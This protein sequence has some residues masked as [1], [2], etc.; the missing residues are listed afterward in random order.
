MW[1]RRAAGA[2]LISLALGAC[3]DEHPLGIED[4]S[5]A[6]T[7][8]AANL[9][10][11]QG[12][13]KAVERASLLM[14]IPV[15]LTPDLHGWLSITELTVV[16]QL[17][18][19]QLFADGVISWIDEDGQY[20]AETFENHPITLTPT[21]QASTTNNSDWLSLQRGPAESG[22]CDILYLSLGPLFLDLLGLTVDLSNI[23]LDL[24]ALAGAGNLLGN[25]LCAVTSL[26]DLGPLAALLNLLAQIN[27][28]LD[29]INDLLSGLDAI[30]NI[31]SGDA[32]A[33]L[34]A[35]GV[36]GTA[37]ELSAVRVSN[38]EFRGAFT[39]T[40]IAWSETGETLLVDGIFDGKPHVDGKM[41]QVRNVAVSGVP[42]TLVNPANEENANAMLSMQRAPNESNICDIL[43]LDLAPTFLDVLGLTV[44]LSPIQLDLDAVPGSGNLLGNLLCAVTGLLDGAAGGGLGGL[45][46]GLLQGLLDAINQLLGGLSL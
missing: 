28:I 42:A 9:G 2:L 19:R 14:E 22:V 11:G 1:P 10:R 24:D 44:D 26:L 16:E 6:E 46:Q 15:E 17:A 23:E 39:V 31:F 36:A 8:T 27:D 20:L 37:H 5:L 7:V 25:L 4:P 18:G 45:L 41:V 21:Q 30:G 3:S 12:A 32:T 38:G 33:A 35:A 43:F 40:A 29:A 34:G 13:E